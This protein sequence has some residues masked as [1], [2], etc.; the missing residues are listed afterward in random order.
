MN[1]CIKGGIMKKTKNRMSSKDGRG[2]KSNCRPNSIPLNVLKFYER[3][4]YDQMK[5]FFKGTF[6]IDPSDFP[7]SFNFQHAPTA[8]IGK[9]DA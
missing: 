2:N 1:V 7:K 5:I 6:S 9:N 8:I 3:C 4:F